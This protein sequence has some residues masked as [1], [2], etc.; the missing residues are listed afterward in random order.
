MVATPAAS[1]V[2]PAAVAVKQNV[3]VSPRIAS[4]RGA[5]MPALVKT[6]PITV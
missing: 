1:A 4:L 6:V 3:V 2:K 5:A